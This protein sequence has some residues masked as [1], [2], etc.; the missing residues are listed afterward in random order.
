[1]ADGITVMTFNIRG[2]QH[3]DGANEW[4][5]RARLNVDCIRR[6]A[7]HLV[8]FQEF[9]KGNLKTY[10]AELS[11]YE[12]V[13][14]P[15][16]ENRRPWAYN[17]IYWDPDKLEL[18][19]EGGFWLSETPAK[20]SRSW[21]SSHVRSATWAHFR[22]LSGEEFVHLN[23]HLDHKSVEARVEGSRLIISRLDELTDGELPALVT[24]DFNCNPGFKTY[25]LY[26]AA[27][28]SDAH[29]RAGN[30]R[31]NTFHRFLGR[32]FTPK[33]PDSEA[34]LDW[35]LL[36]GGSRAAWEVE[37]CTVVRDEEPLVYPSDHYP[38][39][40]DLVLSASG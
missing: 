15:G 16:Y 32:D 21:G 34:R 5:R 9:Q 27:R 40:A 3:R 11:G 24:G 14:G 30:A 35:I 37:S 7:P 26:K 33:R 25:D 12:R 10:D 19:D 28:Y 29:L 2:S 4:T 22:T 23:T 20:R 39:L 36:R 13:L 38:V 31:E 6:C 18:L 1:M 17:A 8:G